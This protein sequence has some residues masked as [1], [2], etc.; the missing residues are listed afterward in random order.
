MG[1]LFK[2]IRK[3]QGD[4]R[5]FK[6]FNKIRNDDHWDI[7]L[8]REDAII[9]EATKDVYIYGIGIYGADD[10]KKHDL[11]VKYKWV[12]Q[13]TPNGETIEDSQWFEESS[14]SL[15]LSEMIQ[16]KYF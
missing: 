8:N 12:V 9:F 4:I 2:G 14:T 6:R 1:F 13:R 5:E 7:S 3:S 11:K 15:E 16:N 10:G